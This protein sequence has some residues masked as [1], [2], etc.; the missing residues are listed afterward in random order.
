MTDDSSIVAQRLTSVF[1]RVIPFFAGS[2]FPVNQ[3]QSPRT[4]FLPLESVKVSEEK[5]LRPETTK[6][7]CYYKFIYFLGTSQGAKVRLIT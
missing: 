4:L 6:I 7:T 1:E 2:F 5:P 3:I